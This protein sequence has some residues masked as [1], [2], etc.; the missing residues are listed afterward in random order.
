MVRV[1]TGQLEYCNGLLY[2]DFQILRS[3]KLQRLKN[4]E[5][6]LNKICLCMETS[7]E[8]ESFVLKCVSLKL[9]LFVE[10]WQGWQWT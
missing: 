4:A 9:Y 6:L 2:K 8:L 5:V 1:I 10:F 7:L 3:L